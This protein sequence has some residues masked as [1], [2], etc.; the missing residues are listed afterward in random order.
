MTEIRLLGREAREGERDS[1]RAVTKLLLAVLG[2]AGCGR[3]SPVRM[4]SNQLIILAMIQPAGK[5]K[6][7]QNSLLGY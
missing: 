2:A 7:Q 3:L 6:H 4:L 1:K 5:K